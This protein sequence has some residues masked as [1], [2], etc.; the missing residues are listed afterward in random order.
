[1]D[2]GAVSRDGVDGGLHGDLGT[3]SLVLLR[4][5]QKIKAR[6]RLTE[7]SLSALRLATLAHGKMGTLIPKGA[8]RV[9]GLKS[10]KCIKSSVLESPTD[11]KL[12][13]VLKRRTLLPVSVASGTGMVCSP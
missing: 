11:F 1:M 2:V 3:L 8:L 6:V 10:G 9:S 7:S 4:S 12:L 5:E 13:D